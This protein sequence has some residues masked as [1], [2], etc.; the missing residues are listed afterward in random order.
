MEEEIE[1]KSF[2]KIIQ[3]EESSRPHIETGGF[4]HSTF[5]SVHIPNQATGAKIPSG[6]FERRTHGGE[7]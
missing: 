5:Y 7:N 1:L 2:K 3:T 4:L 6:R